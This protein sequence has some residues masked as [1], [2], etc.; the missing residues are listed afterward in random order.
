MLVFDR[1]SM[2]AR[3]LLTQWET[4][5]IYGENMRFRSIHQKRGRVP[6]LLGSWGLISLLVGCSEKSYDMAGDAYYDTGGMSY[7]AE[8]SYEWDIDGGEYDDGYAE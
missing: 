2:L 8:D 1:F 7:G 5:L 6:N 3:S 4:N